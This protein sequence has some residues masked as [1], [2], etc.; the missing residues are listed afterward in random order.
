M[1]AA[2][3]ESNE[4]WTRGQVGPAAQMPLPVHATQLYES[5]ASFIIFLALYFYIRPRRRAYGQVFGWMLVL[6]YGQLMPPLTS[7]CT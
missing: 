1:T 7:V 2:K 4:R 3:S 5:V 6:Y